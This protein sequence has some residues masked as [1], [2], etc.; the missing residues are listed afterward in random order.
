[1]RRPLA[2]TFLILAVAA[3]AAFYAARA[4]TQGAATPQAGT[5][6]GQSVEASKLV[7]TGALQNLYIVGLS[8]VGISALF[9][10]VW[11]GLLYMTAGDNSSQIGKAKEKFTNAAWGIAIAAFSYAVLN[12]INPDLVKFQLN[13]KGIRYKPASELK[14]PG[15]TSS[16]SSSSAKSTGTNP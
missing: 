1:M 8:L 11:G 6:T 16:S 12:T 4:E 10:V 9:M 7:F 5:T 2:I 13:F 15:G 14:V 3:S